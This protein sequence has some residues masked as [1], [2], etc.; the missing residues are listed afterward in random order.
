VA[1]PDD[2]VAVPDG[3]DVETAALLPTAETA[4]ALVMDGAPLVGERAVVFGAGV[5]G[6]ATT[7]LLSSFPLERL[8]VVEP[9]PARRSLASALGADETLPPDRAAAVG[10]RGDPPGADLVF[11][12]S[13]SPDALDGAVDAVG[14]DGR[15]VVGSWYG[16]KRVSADLGGFFH[17]NRVD[18]V[19]SQVSTLAPAH[20]G[21]WTTD[22]RLDVALDRLAT[23]ETDRLLTHR[24]PFEDAAEAY[25]LLDERPDEAVQ[26]LLT[27]GDRPQA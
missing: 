5:V 11:E 18:I 27:Y 17:R 6:L 12:L 10:H 16:R 19:S 13:G 15:V 1:T 21:R 3:M 8:T 22:R 25:R 20:R 9:I 14:Y 4:T 23:L 2:L 24:V 7:A 26:V